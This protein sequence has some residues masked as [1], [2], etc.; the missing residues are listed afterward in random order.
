MPIV[1]NLIG[2]VKDC[3]LNG[4]L[5][6]NTTKEGYL[7]VRYL[8]DG[9]EMLICVSGTIDDIQFTKTAK[10]WQ[11]TRK[12]QLSISETYNLNNPSYQKLSI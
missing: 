3:T 5:F 11:V 7:H 2:T 1:M 6:L 10:G 9:S 4:R 8:H 12:L